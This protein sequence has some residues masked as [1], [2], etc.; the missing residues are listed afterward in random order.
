MSTWGR[1]QGGEKDHIGPS[2]KEDSG[3]IGSLI[4]G[5]HNILDKDRQPESHPEAIRIRKHFV[6]GRLPGVEEVF[7]N[8]RVLSA[9]GSSRG[10]IAPFC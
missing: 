6:L 4:G 5:G 8:T 10:S 7:S 3:L 2:E 9:G 1:H